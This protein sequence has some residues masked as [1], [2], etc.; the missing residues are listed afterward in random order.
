MTGERRRSLTGWAFLL[1]AAVLIFL[2]SFLPM[3]Q[4]FLLSLQ[5][6]RGANLSYAQPFWLNYERLLQD[7]IFRLTLQNTFIYLI[8]QVPVMLIMALVLANLLNTRNLKFKTFW[9]T[10]IFLPCAVSLVAYSL[11]FRTIFANDG[12][13]NDVL[14]GIGLMDSPINWLGNPD[15]GRFVI[16]LGLLWRWTGY[17]MVFYLAALQNVDYSSIEA[18]R[19]D[20]ANAL[21]TFW[22][23]TIPQLKPIILLTAIM[24]TNGTLQLFDESWALTRGGPAY[25]TMSMSHY[26]YEVSFL[27]NPNF[28]YASAL[29]YV[30]LILVAVLAFVQLKVGDKRD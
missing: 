10:A 17:N 8:I 24:S 23:V 5:T 9:R 30:I 15:T 21:Q 19:M 18:A 12:F 3:I 25:T 1:P 28:G 11:V 27:K 14:M 13:V 2:V 29:S 16:I 26:L 4:A 20:G 7:E 22:H 6:G